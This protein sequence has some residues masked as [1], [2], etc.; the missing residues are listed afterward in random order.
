LPADHKWAVLKA[1]LVRTPDGFAFFAPAAALCRTLLSGF[2][3]K[4]AWQQPISA[5]TLELIEA[6]SAAE[7]SRMVF[8]AAESG[9]GPVASTLR[10]FL[11]VALAIPSI[12]S[13]RPVL[14]AWAAL[15][16]AHTPTQ[17]LIADLPSDFTDEGM[18]IAWRESACAPF[19][20][21]LAVIAGKAAAALKGCSVRAARTAVTSYAGYAAILAQEIMPLL[22]RA[23]EGVGP[24]KTALACLP[25]MEM[26]VAATV[27]MLRVQADGSVWAA[28]QGRGGVCTA[29]CDLCLVVAPG[30]LTRLRLRLRSN[31]PTAQPA[32]ACTALHCS[33]LRRN[34]HQ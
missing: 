33:W 13:Y 21:R 26:V 24:N 4:S 28:M 7:F 14:R 16:L 12:R 2:A 6:M 15:H 3:K 27:L 22:E 29:A 30:H 23:A 9:D 18:W 17:A 5:L 8:D 1:G 10:L 31:G 34:L 11:G 25:V 32:L 19:Q 20:R